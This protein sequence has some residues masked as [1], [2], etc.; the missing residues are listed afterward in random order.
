MDS[1]MENKIKNL[2]DE[3]EDEMKDDGGNYLLSHISTARVIEARELIIKEAA[4][5]GQTIFY[6]YL[7]KLMGIDIN[8]L[9]RNLIGWIL[10]FVSEYEKNKDRPLLS[11]LVVSVK[12]NMP[13]G[14]FF[15][16]FFEGEMTSDEKREAAKKE[17]EMCFSF[18]KGKHSKD[19]V[20]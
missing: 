13:S 10:F 18:W 3:Y 2:I 14:R 20:N 12:E 9:N 8:S 16:A 6:S 7:M 19:L 11:S 1:K 15:A 17:Q 5:K 4:M